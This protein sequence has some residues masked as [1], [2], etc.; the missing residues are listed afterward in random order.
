M[1]SIPE[2]QA[3]LEAELDAIKE[4][5]DRNHREAVEWR[6]KVA[7]TLDKIELKLEG[8]DGL[9]NQAKGV[10]WLAGIILMGIGTLVVI[11][12]KQI[13]TWLWGH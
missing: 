1:P 3:R 6:T 2:R 9:L 12:L 5:V 7:A 4:T 10:R 11:G 13:V 8:F